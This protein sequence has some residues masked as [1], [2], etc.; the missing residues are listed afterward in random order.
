FLWMTARGDSKKVDQAKQLIVSAIVGVVIIAAAYGITDLVIKSVT[1][2]GQTSTETTA[3][4]SPAGPS[5][6]ASCN[7]PLDCGGIPDSCGCQSGYSCKCA[8]GSLSTNGFPCPSSGSCV[9][10]S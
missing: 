1:G 9:C 3:A 5:C 7:V 4:E 2:A 8:D 6:S 10:S